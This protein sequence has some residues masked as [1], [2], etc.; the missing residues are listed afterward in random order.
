MKVLFTTH[1]MKANFFLS[2]LIRSGI[3]GNVLIFW[4]DSMVFSL[5]VFGKNYGPVVSGCV[6]VCGLNRY[7]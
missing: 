5:Y 6:F 2:Q 1:N 7:R 4:C 3:C